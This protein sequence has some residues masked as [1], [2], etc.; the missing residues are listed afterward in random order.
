MLFVVKSLY[1]AALALT[2]TKQQGPLV[3]SFCIFG[4]HHAAPSTPLYAYYKND[5]W[6]QVTSPMITYVLRLDASLVGAAVGFLP[7][8]VS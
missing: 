8:Y 2:I 6:C 4:N 5:R 7:E 1:K 3:D